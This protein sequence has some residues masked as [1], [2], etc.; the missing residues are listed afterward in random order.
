M[1]DSIVHLEKDDEFAEGYYFIDETSRYQG[2]FATREQAED[3]FNDYCDYLEGLL[4]V[5]EES[6][7]RGTGTTDLGLQ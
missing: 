1:R 6:N 2:P 7:E 3:R 4:S 5:K